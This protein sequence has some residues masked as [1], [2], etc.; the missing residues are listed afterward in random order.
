M[1]SNTS[2]A[3]SANSV[4][5]MSNQVLSF[6]MLRMNSNIVASDGYYNIIQSSNDPPNAISGTFHKMG[7]VV[8]VVSRFLTRSVFLTVSFC[9]PFAELEAALFYCRRWRA[10]LLQS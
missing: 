2:V 5:T 6:Y 9:I 7:H 4:A 3:S 1:S 8:K 10:G